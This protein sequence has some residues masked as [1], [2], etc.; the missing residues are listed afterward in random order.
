[1]GTRRSWHP[2]HNPNY[3]ARVRLIGAAVA[4]IVLSGAFVLLTGAHTPD[5][6]A[7]QYNIDVA[8]DDSLQPQLDQA[9][10]TSPAESSTIVHYLVQTLLKEDRRLS[11]GHWPTHV[12]FAIETL[13]TINQQ[14][15]S[16]LNKY[17]AASLSER[18]ILLQQQS[19]DALSAAYYDSQI[20]VM[21]GA[22]PTNS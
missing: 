12:A 11:A 9:L 15:I 14:Q 3:A 1:M 5:K 10:H 18:A 16:V 19:N 20:R 21:L 2:G 4:L 13:V 8:K 7:T 6:I 17:A 22:S